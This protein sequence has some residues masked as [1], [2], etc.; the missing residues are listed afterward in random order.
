MY[1]TRYLAQSQSTPPATRSAH[2][3]VAKDLHK[4]QLRDLLRV[5]LRPQ[6]LNGLQKRT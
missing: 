6:N 2:S 1:L 4:N 5:D 3:S